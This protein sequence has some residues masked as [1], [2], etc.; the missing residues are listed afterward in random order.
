MFN[1]IVEDIKSVKIQGA[2]NIAKASIQ[3]LNEVYMSNQHLSHQ[4]L[5]KELITARNTLKQTRPTEPCMSNTLKFLFHD[6]NEY[7]LK[8]N[9]QKNVV[10]A[11]N[12]FSSS[13]KNIFEI[14]EKKI[15]RGY[16]VFTFCHSSTVMG[17]IKAAYKHKKFVVNN[18]ET[19]PLLQ[20]RK[21]AEELAEEGIK[22]NHYV[23]SAMRLAIKDSD[24]VLIGADAITSEGKAI[25][26]I[27]SELV[28]EI[29]HKF[30]VPV[31]ICTNSWK[32]DPDTV[33]GFDEKIEQRHEQEIWSYPPKGVTVN[34]YAFE[35]V[36]P[37]LITGVISELGIY[38][39]DVFIEELKRT[40][41]WLFK[42]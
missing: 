11:K 16:K 12:H 1:K 3:A 29:A 28:A 8:Q 41:P 32:F 23:D 24:I 26:K 17:I 18:T 34:N 27:G 31:Y 10:N 38:S 37:E 36:S 2:E 33:F 19:R 13:D 20:G 40:S 15:A 9:F 39:P 14:G 21:T 6:I 30:D 7:N 42:K 5:Y 4:E 25:N 35:I 22:V